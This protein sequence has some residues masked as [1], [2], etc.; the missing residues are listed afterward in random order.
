[1]NR[2]FLLRVWAL[3]TIFQNSSNNEDDIDEEDEDEL[4]NKQI[5]EKMATQQ[6]TLS[7][8]NPLENGNDSDCDILG[9]KDNDEAL[10]SEEELDRKL[11]ES[12]RD[13]SNSI[14]I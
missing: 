4:L 11:G 13:R 14:P 7:T 1:M 12:N 3:Q 6:R 5:K 9:D 8:S 2:F 10:D